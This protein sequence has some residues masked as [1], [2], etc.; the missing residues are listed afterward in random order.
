MMPQFQQSPLSCFQGKLLIIWFLFIMFISQSATVYYSIGN[1]A[2]LCCMKKLHVI[3]RQ[4]S[5]GISGYTW[6]CSRRLALMCFIESAFSLPV[7]ACL[8]PHLCVCMRLHMYACT[9]C[10]GFSSA[11]FTV[12][13]SA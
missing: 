1:A 8:P 4:D 10:M 11:C 2:P 13:Q 12:C 7:V 3:R 9:V 6:V 5:R